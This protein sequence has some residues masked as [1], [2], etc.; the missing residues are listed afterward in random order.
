MTRYLKPPFYVGR[1]PNY[2]Q[3]VLFQSNVFFQLKIGFANFVKL[4]VG[5][6]ENPEGWFEPTGVGQKI[7]EKE[8]VFALTAAQNSNHSNSINEENNV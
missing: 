4:F 5:V 1:S 6:S 2:L 8:K 7:K 3:F